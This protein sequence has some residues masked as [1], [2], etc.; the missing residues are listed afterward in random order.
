[1]PMY[2][3]HCDS[4]G[5]DFSM[6]LKISERNDPE[7]SDCPHCT[8]QGFVR[9]KIGTPLVSYSTNPGMKT[10]DNFNARLQEIAKNKGK[11]HTINTR[12]GGV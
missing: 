1:M 5:Q 9:M 3:Y 7:L 8:V 2:E 4:C 6:R 12:F 10:S 11:G